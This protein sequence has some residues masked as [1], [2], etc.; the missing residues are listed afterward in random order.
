[1]LESILNQGLTGPSGCLRNLGGRREQPTLGVGA[2][3]GSY[4]YWGRDRP[5]GLVAALVGFEDEVHAFD[6]NQVEAAWLFV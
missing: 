4:L 6:E 3:W 5:I 2:C 1:M